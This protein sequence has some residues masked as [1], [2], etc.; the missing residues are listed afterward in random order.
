MKQT[1]PHLKLNV[2]RIKLYEKF[3]Y[4]QRDLSGSKK[5]DNDEENSDEAVPNYINKAETFSYSLSSLSSAQTLRYEK[6]NQ[7]LQVPRHVDYIKIHFHSQFNIPKYFNIYYHNYGLLAVS[8]TRFN[9][10][11]L[12]AVADTFKFSVLL[13][14]LEIFVKLHLDNGRTKTFDPNILFIDKFELLSSNDMINL[15]LS[16]P[17]S[18][19]KLELIDYPIPVH[20]PNIIYDS[21][22]QYFEQRQIIQELNPTTQTVEIQLISREDLLE[23]VDNFDIVQNVISGL[24]TII[25]PSTYQ[26]PERSYGFEIEPAN[27]N[28]PIVGI[29]DTGISN[30]TPL[31]SIL[32]N[33]DHLNVTGVSSF[34]DNAN[35]GTGVAGLAALGRDPYLTGYR[36]KFSADARLLSIK[37][38]DGGHGG[39]SDNDVLKLLKE[40][41][42]KYPQ[43]KIYTL[44]IC[45]SQNK[46]DDEEI[47]RYAYELDK[48]AHENDCLIFICTSNNNHASSVN[49]DYDHL[50][51]NQHHCNLS[52]PSESMNNITIGAAAECFRDGTFLGISPSKEYPTLYS[53]KYHV[54]FRRYFKK[55][56]INNRIFKPDVIEAGGDYELIETKYLKF[57][58]KGPSASVQVISSDPTESFC[59]SIG[60]SFS[61]PLAAN[62][63][64]K[65]LKKYPNL[66][67]QTI[68][69]LI[70][71]AASLSNIG[72]PIPDDMLNRIAG[73]G[74]VDPDKTVYSDNNSAT[75]IIEDSIEPEI[76]QTYPIK[77]PEYLIKDDLKKQNQLVRITATLCFSFEPVLHNQL[78]YC[79]IFM[80]FSVFRNK[81]IDDIKED[82]ENSI[83]RARWTQDGYYKT[84]P[85]ANSNTHKISFT[86]GV[87]ELKDESNTF[88]IAVLCK[89][90]SQL[91]PGQI[92]KYKLGHNFSLVV[93]IEEQ[94]PEKRLTGKLYQGL[95][96]ENDIEVLDTVDLDNELNL[97]LEV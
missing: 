52:V 56:K 95:V 91:I 47:S 8:F 4:K 76:I 84:N 86:I 51:F 30:T 5:R 92:E 87:K 59:Y 69:A 58:D 34:I 35:H 85:K 60:T 12:F 37:I 70:V 40:A 65:I 88:K 1:N 14:Q 31:R 6:R 55:G 82:Y 83:L 15:D 10:T 24:A 80:A 57:I 66:R 7:N 93:K 43:L 78:S 13:N 49:T 53:R 54:D 45:Y 16:K 61:A 75:I 32:I 33:D 36:G 29:I 79:P 11:V 9:S 17:L 62:I 73:H 64:A 20:T 74:L 18:H 3:T 39:I 94:L 44:T 81:D 25:S 42:L 28:L 2:D 67:S 23:V 77:F 46:K 26:Q 48:F 96:S 97:D 27:E 72:H 21:L 68:K 63:A 71:N 90:G 89:L 41:K 19:I 38:L 22:V 50:Y